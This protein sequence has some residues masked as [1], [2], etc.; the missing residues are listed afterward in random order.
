MYKE[1]L[2]IN[3]QENYDPTR[4]TTLRNS[5]AR[6]MRVRFSSFRKTLKKSIIEQDCFGL[7]EI[8]VQGVAAKREFD[9]I[10]SSDKVNAFMKWMRR[11]MDMELLEIHIMQ[12]TGEAIESAWTN[13]FIKDSYKRGVIRARN[14]LRNIQSGVASIEETG[15]I[16]IAMQNPF[17]AD[18][19]GV[20]YTRVFRDLKGITDAMDLQ[21]SRVLTMGIMDGDNPRLLAKKLD[22]VIRGGGADLGITD[23]LGRYIPAERRAQILARTE[24]IRAHHLATVQEYRNWGLAGVKVKAEFTTAGDNRVC[25]R[26]ADLEGEIYTLDQIQNKIPVHPQC[27]CIALP[28]KIGEKVELKDTTGNIS[29]ASLEQLKTF[30]IEVGDNTYE[31]CLVVREGEKILYKAGN[32]NQ[33]TF[34]TEEL[35][36]MNNTIF[37][38]NHP[39]GSSFSLSD[40]ILMLKQ[41]ITEIRAFNKNKNNIYRMI[42]TEEGLKKGAFSDIDIIALENKYENI[43][44]ELYSEIGAKI[45]RKEITISEANML[46]HRELWKQLTKDVRWG[47]YIQYKEEVFWKP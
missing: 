17:H 41:N 46:H 43:N 42:R 30:E 5:F 7:E 2:H 37:T 12:Q 47:K 36:S 9:F 45:K 33:I 11:Q 35:N 3:N 20:L 16:D 29:P 21:I 4:T 44:N 15:G 40:I 13:T 8:N 25:S 19:L 38:H 14:E 24:I 39:G 22:A 34:I 18:R 10:R 1:T 6:A 32:K 26:C 23:T 27:R 28:A 31:S